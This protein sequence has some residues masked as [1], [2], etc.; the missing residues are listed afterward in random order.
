MSKLT[1]LER[2]EICKKIAEI[3]GFT[4]KQVTIFM[5]CKGYDYQT[6]CAKSI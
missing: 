1:D 2:L 5:L 3:E 4:A 6:H